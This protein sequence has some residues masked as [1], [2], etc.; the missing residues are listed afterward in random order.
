MKQKRSHVSILKGVAFYLKES[1]NVNPILW[2]RYY[3]IGYYLKVDLLN[4]G[5]GVLVSLLSYK[6]IVV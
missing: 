5:F 4:T 6:N 1:I 2:E 3:K